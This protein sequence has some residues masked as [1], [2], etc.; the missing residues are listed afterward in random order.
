MSGSLLLLYTS[1]LLVFALRP[2]PLFSFQRRARAGECGVS[3]ID[4]LLDWPV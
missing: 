3:D 1:Q 2:R 4:Y